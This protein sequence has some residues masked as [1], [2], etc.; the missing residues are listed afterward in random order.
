M[1][2]QV[3]GATVET[4]GQ[5]TVAHLLVER[6]VKMPDRVVVELNGEVLDRAAFEHTTLQDGDKVE[7]LYFMGGGTWT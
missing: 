3:N 1:N 6:E 2:I 5:T 4:G 7:F